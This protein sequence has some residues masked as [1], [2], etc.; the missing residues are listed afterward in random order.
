MKR[1]SIFIGVT[2]HYNQSDYRQCAQQAQ[3]TVFKNNG[4]VKNNKKQKKMN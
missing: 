3:K 4:P 1:V 2:P